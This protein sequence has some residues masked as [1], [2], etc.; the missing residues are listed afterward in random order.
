MV[1]SLERAIVSLAAPGTAYD[2][3][4]LGKDL[5]PA[6][7]RDYLE[8]QD[9]NGGIHVNAGILNRAFYLT[10]VA[11]GGFAWEKAGW[12]WYE[13]LRDKKLKSDSQFVDFAA[14]TQLV[15]ARRYGS[16]GSDELRAVK[17]AWD[18]VGVAERGSTRAPCPGEGFCMGRRARGNPASGS[19]PSAAEPRVRSGPRDE[20]VL[21]TRAFRFAG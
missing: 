19:E 1:S 18:L 16:T 3:P 7:M 8:T 17:N 14:M 5:Q 6:H 12:I 10:A 9:D 2:D 13:A 20:C 11:L 15:A 21:K 4:I